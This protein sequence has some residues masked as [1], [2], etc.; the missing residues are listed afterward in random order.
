M[1]IGERIKLKREEL[2]M[3]QDELAKKRDTNQDHPSIK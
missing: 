1:E 2:N 3:S